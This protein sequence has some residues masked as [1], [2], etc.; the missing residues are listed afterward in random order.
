MKSCSDHIY[1]FQSA[2]T[3]LQAMN[4][5]RISMFVV[6]GFIFIFCLLL[7]LLGRYLRKKEKQRRQF[8]K[9]EDCEQ[10]LYWKQYF[11]SK[12]NSVLIH[13]KPKIC[14]ERN[15]LLEASSAGN[16]VSEA[17]PYTPSIASIIDEGKL[18]PF[19]I[20]KQKY[21]SHA[22]YEHQNTETEDHIDRNKIIK[23][24][25][26]KFNVKKGKNISLLRKSAIRKHIDPNCN[27]K[28]AE[29]ISVARNRTS[30][31]VDNTVFRV[32]PVDFEICWLKNEMKVNL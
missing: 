4:S 8:E 29:K 20:R 14:P 26:S 25:V 22:R 31:T 30:E 7:V 6:F 21:K 23:E 2:K 16:N 1:K 5:L 11:A 3:G 18:Q 24:P 15:I 12:T 17:K 19:P 9:M 13:Q 28:T 27:Y 10:K 32:D